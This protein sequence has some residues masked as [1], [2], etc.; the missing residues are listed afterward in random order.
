MLNKEL[1][2]DEM[3]KLLSIHG[4]G[5]DRIPVDMMRLWYEELKEL[6]DKDFISSVKRVKFSPK[7]SLY[8]ILIN[9]PGF[10]KEKH[11]DVH[12]YCN[13]TYNKP[14]ISFGLDNSEFEGED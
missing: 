14:S 6:K 10:D 9:L 1:F 12:D 3:R 11:K 5:I 13:R 4:I 7:L 8:Y 2:K